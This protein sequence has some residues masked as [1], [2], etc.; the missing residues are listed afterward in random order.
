MSATNRG[1]KRRD[2]DFYETPDWVTE[3]IINRLEEYQI[4]PGLYERVLEP[5]A[6]K[7]AIIRVMRRMQRPIQHTTAVELL[8]SNLVHLKL[9]TMPNLLVR[10]RFQ[11][12]AAVNAGC[13]GGKQ[14]ERFSLIITNP[15]YRLAE[16]FVRR[17]LPLLAPGGILALLLRLG[18]LEGQARARLHATF[19][20]DVHPLSR[21]PSFTGDGS[22]DATAYAW[23]VWGGLGRP[24]AGAGRWRLLPL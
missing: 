12:F 19:P 2:G 8:P 5:A 13:R 11:D 24:L 3:A 10:G 16:T 14:G 22:T 4:G 18:F 7:G 6:G 1:A 17:S 21:R 9:H 15:P 20:C 23:L